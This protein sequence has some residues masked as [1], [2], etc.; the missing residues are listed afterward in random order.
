MNSELILQLAFQNWEYVEF[1]CILH[2]NQRLDMSNLIN[3]YD[4]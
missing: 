4:L 3:F 2:T 1:S